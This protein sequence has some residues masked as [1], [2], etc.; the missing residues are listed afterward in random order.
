MNDAATW[1]L[2]RS[3]VDACRRKGDTTWEEKGKRNRNRRVNFTCS[4]AA[5]DCLESP[6][7]VQLSYQF[8]QER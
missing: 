6:G 4:S 5:V 3:V 2:G 7:N 1:A 8:G